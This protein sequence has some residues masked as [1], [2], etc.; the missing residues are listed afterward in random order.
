MATEL[1]FETVRPGYHAAQ[2]NEVLYISVRKM[3]MGWYVELRD[4]VAKGQSIRAI[5]MC[6]K[7]SEAK[8]AASNFARRNF[9]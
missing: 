8:E 2:I 9:S 7:F 4:T 5:E 3:E 1:K 6:K